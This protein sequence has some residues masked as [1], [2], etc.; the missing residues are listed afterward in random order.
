MYADVLV[1]VLMLMN[2]GDISY[3]FHHYSIL[4]HS[5]LALGAAG[6]GIYNKFR[7]ALFYLLSW[8]TLLI[9]T[10]LFSLSNLGIFREY[11]STSSAGL[12][13]ACLLQMLF[14]SFALGN[15]WNM[16]VKENHQAKEMELRRRL[17]ENA[18]LEELVRLRTEEI[19]H[20]N[21]KLEEVNRIKDKLF[22][23]VS[24]DIKGPLTALQLALS[25]A[26]D[27][28]I[29]QKEFQEL[30]NALETRFT[31]TT[32]FI[33]NLLQWA[34]VQLKGGNFQPAKFDFTELVRKTVSVFDF[35]IKNKNIILY[36]RV[37]S[38]LYAFA[39]VNMVRSVLRNLITNAIK[40]TRKG[41]TIIINADVDSSFI[42]V[43]VSDTGIGIPLAHQKKLFSLDS[44]TTLGTKQEKGTGLGLLLSKE[45]IDRNGGEIWCESVEGK[46]T[47]FHFTIPV[48]V[49]SEVPEPTR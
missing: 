38:P 21:Q 26:K 39:D 34:T 48:Y 15:R 11:L 10:F 45:F 17:L 25:L 2:I 16:M 20:K 8:L 33:E 31:Q 35:E 28:T 12:I 6:I 3:R 42:S 41:D 49:E 19:Q 14:I 1:G 9:A 40:F 7:P 47:T 5:L 13:V 24:H 43:S 23:V 27:N 18:E 4:I 44:V 29:S 30:T 22:S 36:N 46:G 32:E 37:E